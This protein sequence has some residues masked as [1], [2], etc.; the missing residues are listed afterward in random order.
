MVVLVGKIDWKGPTV[1]FALDFA[2]HLVDPR[3]RSG[4]RDFLH[5]AITLF[6]LQLVFFALVWLLQADLSGHT[7]LPAN[8][9]FCWMGYA[10]ASRRLHDL[11][12]SSWWMPAAVACWIVMGFLVALVIALIAGPSAVKPGSPGFWIAFLCLLAP[13]FA[14]ALWLHLAAGENGPNRYGPP[15]A[16]DYDD[17]VAA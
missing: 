10:A 1:Q 16:E 17:T 3:G 7:A 8:A 14:V 5:V 15:P 6:V 4:R 9:A 12:R 11:G 2:P 13:P